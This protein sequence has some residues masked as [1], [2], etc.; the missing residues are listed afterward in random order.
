MREL[1]SLRP[2]KQKRTIGG[3]EVGD[4]GNIETLVNK[5]NKAEIL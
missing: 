2:K 3:R 5:E 4:I 1:L